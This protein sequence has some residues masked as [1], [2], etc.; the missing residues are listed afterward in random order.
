MMT[1]QARPSTVIMGL[2]THMI[3][4][5]V[6][7]LRLNRPNGHRGINR[8]PRHYAEALGTSLPPE[9]QAGMPL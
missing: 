8:T 9:L 7:A 1:K 4:E 2:D 5:V 3:L 6:P